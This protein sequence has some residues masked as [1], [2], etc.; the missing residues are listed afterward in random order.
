MEPKGPKTYQKC[1]LFVPEQTHIHGYE[2]RDN[3]LS[4]FGNGQKAIVST[5]YSGMG[6]A[7][8][9]IEQLSEPLL[10]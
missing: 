4:I 3:L 2:Q 1:C 5:D 10:Q 6:C 9:A 8:M 7:E